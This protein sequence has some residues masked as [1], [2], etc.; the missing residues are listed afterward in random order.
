MALINT[1]T[2][3]LTKTKKLSKWDDGNKIQRKYNSIRST[4]KDDSNGYKYKKPIYLG[5]KKCVFEGWHKSQ[6]LFFFAV[7][8]QQMFTFTH[9]STRNKLK[10]TKESAQRSWP[11]KFFL[12]KHQNRFH[13][14]TRKLNKARWV[15]HSIKWNWSSFSTISG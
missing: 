7:M 8:R 5:R 4:R 11:R 9:F 12:F 6:I 1:N 13:R 10:K 14:N 2:L 15:N 3:F